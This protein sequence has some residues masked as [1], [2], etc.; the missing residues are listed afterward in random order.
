MATCRTSR[1]KVICQGQRPFVTWHTKHCNLESATL[2]QITR[3][4]PCL[5]LSG[6]EMVGVEGGKLRTEA[7]SFASEILSFFQIFL[8]GNI[9]SGGKICT[10]CQYQQ[11]FSIK[12]IR[13]LQQTSYTLNR[14][15][16][17]DLFVAK[18]FGRNCT[19]NVISSVKQ[20]QY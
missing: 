11:E 7:S 14:A 12:V 19:V 1:S 15:S 13:F 5:Y 2:I 6:H 3:L 17:L 16:T 9:C 8:C 18:H 20:W 4:L 10:V